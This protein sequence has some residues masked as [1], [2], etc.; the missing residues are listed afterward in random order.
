MQKKNI[1]VM[2]KASLLYLLFASIRFSFEIT[3]HGEILRVF[4][5]ANEDEEVLSIKKGFAGM[6]S[7][8]L[9]KK[10]EVSFMP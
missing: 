3:R 1:L 2:L 10:D 9:H 7:A 5:P 8:K 6:L 4:H